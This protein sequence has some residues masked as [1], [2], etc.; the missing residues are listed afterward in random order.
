[1]GCSCARCRSPRKESP[2]TVS[3][4]FSAWVVRLVLPVFAVMSAGVVFAGGLG[5]VLDDTAALG[6]TPVS[7]VGKTVGIAGGSWVTTKL[8][9]RN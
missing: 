1:M 8:T 4:T 5:A 7:V 9:P 2:A 6:I 3:P